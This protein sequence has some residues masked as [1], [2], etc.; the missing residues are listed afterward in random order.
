[1]KSGREREGAGR[2]SYL[3][4]AGGGGGSGRGQ[5]WRKRSVCA[6]QR[7]QQQ[8]QQQQLMS[9]ILGRRQ[10][11]WTFVFFRGA[12]KRGQ[13]VFHGPPSKNPEIGK[14]YNIKKFDSKFGFKSIILVQMAFN[15]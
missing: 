4:G 5:R 6:L 1:M 15:F 7:P 14:F 3:E 10:F 12:C 2:A 9:F 8:Q 11:L 13:R